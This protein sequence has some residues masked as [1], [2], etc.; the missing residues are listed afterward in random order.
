VALT[1]IEPSVR[2]F[3]RRETASGAILSS[4]RPG[5]VVP[6]PRPLRRLSD[7]L[8]RASASFVEKRG[9]AVTSLA[10]R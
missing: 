9:D 2:R 7:P 4:R 8:T 1:I 5:N 10:G 6:P 3:P